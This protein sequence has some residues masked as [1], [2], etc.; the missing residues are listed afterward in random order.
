[1]QT[2]EARLTCS[3]CGGEGVPVDV[4]ALRGARCAVCGLFWIV[5]PISD[6]RHHYEE[7]FSGIKFES[8]HRNAM[9]QVAYASKY[10]ELN[11]LCDVGCGDGTFLVA[12]REAGYHDLVG[13]EPSITAREL[14]SK[15]GVSVFP[16]GIESLKDVSTRVPVR[17]VTLMHV[18][19]H[20]ENP[21]AALQDVY[22]SLPSGG[23]VVVETPQVDSFMLRKTN[24]NHDLV[25]PEHL[26]LFSRRSLILGLEGVGFRV[27]AQGKRD[28]DDRNLSI[29]QSLVRLGVL[30]Y[31]P[32]KNR[33]SGDSHPDSIQA[34]NNN[35]FRRVVRR[36]L[37]ELVL[38]LGRVDYQ[39]V[40][41][42][43]F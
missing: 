19:E 11:A 34:A 5:N 30:S 26:F 16:G 43:K 1:M 14:A 40:I 18:L 41:A 24:L 21:I 37:N 36:I 13:I 7:K 12:V 42:K 27:V 38:L 33:M 28:F 4:R 10:I 20:L 39:W 3:V 15:N 9:S 29:R 35:I 25:Y 22:E 32:T 23:Y 31:A 6:V 2:M 17:V 8:R